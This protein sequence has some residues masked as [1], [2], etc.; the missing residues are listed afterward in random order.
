MK[1]MKRNRK[2]RQAIGKIGERFKNYLDVCVAEYQKTE[3]GWCGRDVVIYPNVSIVFP[4]NIFIESH[5]HIGGCMIRASERSKI[6]I[7]KWCQIANNTIFA[8]S[9]HAIGEGYYYGNLTYGDIMLEDNVWIGSNAIILENV[10]IG[11]N[12]VIAAGAVVTKDVPKNVIVAGV[13]ARVIKNI[14]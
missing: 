6:K 2:V 13:P 14:I 3:L 5:T 11:A 7:G 4:K 8:S 9:G 1:R 10:K 12:S